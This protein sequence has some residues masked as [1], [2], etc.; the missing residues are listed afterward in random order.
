MI[1]TE[2]PDG[3]TGSYARQ[4]VKLR[5]MIWFQYLKNWGLLG[6]A[7]FAIFAASWTSAHENPEYIG[8]K[9]SEEYCDV[10]MPH[11]PSHIS[12]S[13]Q[14]VDKNTVHIFIP[15][16]KIPLRNNRNV[17]DARY[18]SGPIQTIKA[19]HDRSIRG[20]R[21][22]I[23]LKKPASPRLQHTDNHLTIRFEK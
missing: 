18:F 15:D 22:E 16:Y 12:A 23:T 21:V 10:I 14:R 17:L 1:Q 3:R 11:I 6:L 13:T 2:A 9:V 4:H 19:Y 8:L 7:L 20:T 5:G